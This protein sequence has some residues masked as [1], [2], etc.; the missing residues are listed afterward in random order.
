M[1]TNRKQRFQALL[2]HLDERMRRLIAAVETIGL[3]HDC[4]LLYNQRLC[5]I[6]EVSRDTGVSRRGISLG[7]AEL[8]NTIEKSRSNRQKK[9]GY[10]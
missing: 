3:G 1:D 7:L 4:E 6:S 8:K 2:P 9:G 5:G 10:S